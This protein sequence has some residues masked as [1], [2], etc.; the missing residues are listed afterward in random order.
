MT[1]R[2]LP[3]GWTH[4]V[5]AL[6][7]NLSKRALQHP[8]LLLRVEPKGPRASG[9]HAVRC[10]FCRID[11]ATHIVVVC[12]TCEKLMRPRDVPPDAA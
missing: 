5:E 10:Q 1:S 3:S 12:E 9:P 6:K 2:P 8:E 11:A 7:D 4:K